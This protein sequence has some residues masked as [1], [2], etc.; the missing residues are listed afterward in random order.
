MQKT[1]NIPTTKN[2]TVTLSK[3][4][5]NLWIIKDVSPFRKNFERFY[6]EDLNHDISKLTLIGATNYVLDI[7]AGERKRMDVELLMSTGHLDLPDHVEFELVARYRLSAKYYVNN[8]PGRP[9]L[10]AWASS[11]AKDMFKDYPAFA[12]IKIK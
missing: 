11:T 2:H 1:K 12:Y 6:D 8:C 7:L 10:I 5:G 3:E 9:Q 4:I